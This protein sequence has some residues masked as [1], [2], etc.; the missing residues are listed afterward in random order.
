MSTY[1]EMIKIARARRSFCCDGRGL[2]A[3]GATNMSERGREF[4]RAAE[5]KRDDECD[6]TR[7]LQTMEPAMQMKRRTIKDSSLRLSSGKWRSSISPAAVFESCHTALF[8][9]QRRKASARISSSAAASLILDAETFCAAR[10]KPRVRRRPLRTCGLRLISIY[11][12]TYSPLKMHEPAPANLR[13]YTR[14]E[15]T[16]WT[17]RPFGVRLWLETQICIWWSFIYAFVAWR[18]K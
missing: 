14:K 7:A 1:S 9:H 11:A 17:R 12:Q 6:V 5:R 2:C 4:A 8:W 16:C 18:M 3:A 13:N 15:P 10:R